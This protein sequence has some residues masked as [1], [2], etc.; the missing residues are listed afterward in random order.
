VPAP[1]IILIVSTVT[2][3]APA[4]LAALRLVA[5]AIR[6]VSIA[7]I[8]IVPIIPRGA[9]AVTIVSPGGVPATVLLELLPTSLPLGF[10]LLHLL[11]LGA[12]LVVLFLQ[13]Y[14][15]VFDSGRYHCQPLSSVTQMV[16]GFL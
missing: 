1:A 16:L 11:Q 9:A 7:R 2:R 15:V 8:F 14:R 3:A 10:F 4:A 13:R 12:R 6:G 5:T